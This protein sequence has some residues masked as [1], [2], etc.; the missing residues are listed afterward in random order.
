MVTLVALVLAKRKTKYRRS[1]LSKNHYIGVIG[2][3]ENVSEDVLLMAEEVG[4]L[5]AKSG[6]IL[7][8][9]GRF[10]IMEAA[11]K[12]AKSENGL[13]VGILPNHTREEANK[14]VDISIPTG[15]GY[16]LRNFIT[17]RSSDVLIML[18]GEVGT[19]SEAILSY[20]HGKPLVALESTGGWAKRLKT[21]AYDNGSYLDSRNLIKIHYSI[22][23]SEAVST[24]ISLIGTVPLPTKL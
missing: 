4:K 6:N 10:G 14:Y 13:T 20:Q 5:I 2:S 23:P 18:H 9:G 8:C 16:S 12:G 11:C 21:T 3:G 17:V 19:F 15:L 7:V 24:A 1:K 22:T